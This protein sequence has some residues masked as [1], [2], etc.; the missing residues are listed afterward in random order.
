MDT[1]TTQ[2]ERLTMTTK[3]VLIK[4][5]EKIFEHTAQQTVFRN[6]SNEYLYKGL[7]WVYLWWLKASKVKGFLDEQYKQHNIGGHSVVGEEKFTRLL[8][9]TW[10]L[11][12]ADDTKATLQQWS[13][14]LR[15]L[16]AEYEANKDAYRTR[17]QERLAQF[18]ETSGG[19][20]K[21]IGADKYYED[22][23][24]EPIK[25]SKTKSG[26]S[27][28]DAALLDSKHLEMGIKHFATSKSISSIQSTTPIAV[29]R[30]GFALA[31]IK[32]K[33]N[34]TFAVLATLSEE[35]QIRKAIISSYKRDNTAAPTVLQ[36][37]T[38]VIGTQSI[39]TAMERHRDT[40]Q[41]SKKVT[42]ANGEVIAVKQYK[43]LIFR[44]KQRDII[45]SENRTACSVVTVVKPKTSI[46]ASSKDV[47]LRVQDRR[48]LEQAIIQQQDLSIYTAND[49]AKVPVLRDTEVKATH[50]LVLENKLLRSRRAIY[51]Y[52]LDTVGEH[53]RSQ[54]DVN[55]EYKEVAHWTATVDK[56]WIEKLF[57]G[58]VGSWITELGE[59]ITRPKH[60][61]IY[62]EFGKTQ[63][64][65]KHYGERGN[66]KTP[67]QS[68]EITNIGKISKP[69]KTL[70]L[71][72]D[73]MPVL[74]SLAATDIV[75]SLK[76][77]VNEDVLTLSYKT[78]LA[79]YTVSVPT[80]TVSAK[81]NSAAFS[82]YGG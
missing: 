27:E 20:R 31:L 6:R 40:L 2:F 12:W 15:K 47:F 41:D 81:R 9:L 68:F 24:N 76:I 32:A 82:V 59:H 37:L 28:E 8:R 3:Q 25:N 71:T 61:T 50:K 38:E 64:M 42:T 4:E 7:A 45:L 1:E 80:C 65:F 11:D 79:T 60:K 21:L 48:Y 17:P 62:I 26:R 43:R 49:K 30:S 13:L 46:L 54:A 53:S 69:I 74:A 70:F 19:L 51:F 77:A 78:A 52:A 44:K 23:N 33:T 56:L 10:Q 14:A 29:N 35:A 16:H 55:A 34:G 18:I 58:F 63:L 75:G 72:K 73:L 67:S 39:P 5:L 22:G 36:L 57:V 66:L